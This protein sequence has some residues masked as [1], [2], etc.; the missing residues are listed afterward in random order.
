VIF[1]TPDPRIPEDAD[2]REAYD[3][4]TDNII[5]ISDW[6]LVKVEMLSATSA[7]AT[8]HFRV[9]AETKLGLVHLHDDISQFE[10]TILPLP[11][12][13]EEDVTYPLRLKKGRWF[14]VDPPLPRVNASEITELLREDMKALML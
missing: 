5:I 13:R 8:A 1:T 2:V 3:A 12:P 9:V 14:L 7:L 4:K 11:E 10:R 6:H